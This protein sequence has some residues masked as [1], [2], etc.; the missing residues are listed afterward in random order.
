MYRF[1]F[2]TIILIISKCCPQTLQTGLV[3]HVTCWTFIL[4][5][6]CLSRYT[7]FSQRAICKHEQYRWKCDSL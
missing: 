4:I 3:Q 1:V 5:Y 6:I 2:Y 7:Y